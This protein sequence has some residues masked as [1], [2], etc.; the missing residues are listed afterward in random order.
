MADGA[1]SQFQSPLS[2]LHGKRTAKG[3][4]CGMAGVSADIRTKGG[5]MT[6]SADVVSAETLSVS[7]DLPVPEETAVGPDLVPAETIAGSNLAVPE[8]TAVGP[9]IVL[10]ETGVCPDLAV[11][12][13]T[14]VG[15]DLVVAE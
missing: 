10:A 14:A 5:P 4:G 7:Q 9:D 15:P 13:E 11:P 12:E 3:S 6:P 8:A 1:L 2:G